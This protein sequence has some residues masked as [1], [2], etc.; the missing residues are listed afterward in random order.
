MVAGRY[1]LAEPVGH[2]G[3]GRVW[4]GHDQVL[5]REVAVKEVLLSQHLPGA[6]QSELVA[7][8]M[9][10]ARAAA[11]L[12]HPGV[13]TIHDVVEHDGAP[14]IVMQLISGRSLGA[15]IAATG[16]M[17]WQRVA[18]IGEQIADALAHAHAAG[19]VH[20]DLKPDN[21]LLS[22]RRAIVTDFGIARIIDATTA[23]TS[24]GKIIG[25]PQY[26]APEQLEGSSADAAADIWALGAT[27]YT[28]VEGI[29]PFDGPTLTAV[30]AAIL[31]R[32]PF[33]PEHA[34][35][36]SEL[37]GALLAK[38]PS[39]RPDSQTVARAL[40]SR[41]SGRI[42]GSW[43]ATG[44]AA[45]E[46]GQA[47]VPGPTG[48]QAIRPGVAELTPELERFQA[49][50][51]D[52][53]STSAGQQPEPD[54]A[55]QTAERRPDK[56]IT[57][58]ATAAAETPAPPP[59]TE[60]PA[61]SSTADDPSYSDASPPSAPRQPGTTPPVRR[62]ITRQGSAQASGDGKGTPVPRLT[63]RRAL[64]AL[65]G[66]GALAGIAATGWELAQGS[67]S[68]AHV[69]SGISPRPTHT[70]TSRSPSS[71]RATSQATTP[72]SW[73][74]ADLNTVVGAPQA[75][76]APFGYV[77]PDGTARVIYRDANND[78]TEMYLAS[79]QTWKADTLSTLSTVV[80]APQ[81]AS[82]PSAY[83]TGRG[84]PDW[85]ARVIYR[86]ANNDITEM[87]LASGQ[88]WK[89]DTLSTL[90]T[91]VRAPQAA[92]APFGY[93]TPD[94]TARV[95]YRDVNND[96]TEMYLASG[97]TWK[98]DTL[99]TLSTVVGAPQAA[100]APSAYVTG[101]GTPDWTA[102]VIYRDA[103][104]D[105][106]EMYQAPGQPWRQHNLTAV[107]DAAQAASAPFGYVTPDGTA[108]VIYRDVNNDITEMY[109]ASGQ[110]WK[111]DTLST[112]V[113]AAQ[114]ASAPPFGYATPD[115]TARVI[116]RDVNNDITE[117][118]QAP[119][120]PWR[121]HNLTAVADAAQAASAP[122]AYVT[123]DGVARVLYQASNN[124][125]IELRL[126]PGTA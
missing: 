6:D 126:Q 111:A 67:H 39:Q 11:R 70:G 48:E 34:G 33:P 42:T 5:D 21:V 47:V 45:A 4:R 19:I 16:R 66:A 63:R 87:Y 64:F 36:L 23:L 121:Q 80:G 95:I 106:T 97:Q 104:N 2:G 68:Q 28:A 18:E 14:W 26:M 116:Y 50:A 90:S 91:V 85:T 1:L 73:L 24:P 84:T 59:G 58:H 109:L 113:R 9:R 108:R 27:L 49:R 29:P 20:R 110:P 89:A 40:A 77:T 41:R 105:I 56:T 7:R 99:S 44:P 62:S 94:G 53:P 13:V 30:I 75:A 88:P 103:N 60:P 72:S 93:V 12:S 43:A 82:A 76:S 3:M 51:R 102:R 25:T 81:A 71:S 120:Q 8:T 101:R 112:G 119:G 46:S 32:A 17:P 61:V 124:D 114:A 107:A 38:D 52:N 92:S 37:L 57:V 65:A 96:I 123:P 55:T 100:S 15:E 86:D 69:A 83:V 98:A 35:P 10:E 117:M 115:G 78:I 118:Y 31:T 79:G 122:S 125:I 54:N 74:Q 22:G